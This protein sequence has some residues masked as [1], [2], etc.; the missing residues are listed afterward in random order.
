LLILDSAAESPPPSQSTSSRRIVSAG[1][2]ADP[3][4]DSAGGGRIFASYERASD[5]FANN[6]LLYVKG[7]IWSD[8]ITLDW[9][10]GRSEA[11]LKWNNSYLTPALFTNFFIY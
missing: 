1:S 10:K 11:K 9:V 7:W 8:G 5:L 3:N 6:L 4:Q 2:I